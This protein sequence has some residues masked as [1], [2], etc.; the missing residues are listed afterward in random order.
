[1][2]E[3]GARYDPSPAASLYRRIEAKLGVGALN[4]DQDLAR[5]VDQGLPLRAVASLVANG[6]TE[7]EVQELVLPRRTLAHRRARGDALSRDES[8][9]AVRLARL[10]AL[11]EEVFG[12]DAKAAR[13]LRKPKR[14]FEG[15]APLALF[16][17]E[18]GARLVE[19]MLHQ[20]DHGM[21][22]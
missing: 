14:R 10:I 6:V 16:R 8:D 22:A 13:W 11:A 4:S 12:D 20:I 18:A 2:Q 9:R 17:T 21:A 7:A 3:A 15:R 5:A 19:E 1:M